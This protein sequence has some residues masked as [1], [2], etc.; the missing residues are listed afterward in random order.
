MGRRWGKT[1]LGSELLIEAALTGKPVGYFAPTYKLLVPAWRDVAR[2]CLPIIKGAPNKTEHRLE[3]VTGGAI[4]MWSLDGG[5]AG[6]GRKYARV[7]LDECAMV[8]DLEATYNEAIR[9]TLT[10]YKG[11]AWFLSTPKGMNF[12]WKC[13]TYGMS[14]D[15]PDWESWQMPT[16]ANP[17]IDPAEVEDARRQLP[18]RVFRQE[19]LA[20]F[21]EDAGGVFRGAREAV[22]AGR[23]L[24]IE[25]QPGTSYTLG[26]D[27]ARVE[28]FTVLTVLDSQRRQVYFERFNQISWERQITAID[29]CAKRYHARVLVDS[30]GVG[31]PIFEQLR[32]RGLNVEGVQLTNTSKEQ[33]IDALAIAIEQS[34]I[35]L[36]D[37][38][39]QTNE[40]LAYQYELTASRNVRMNAP[41]GMHDDTVIA[42]ALANWGVGSERIPRLRQ[43]GV[44]A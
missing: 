42:L 14:A 8:G 7:V 27:L 40:L 29:A 4:E 15:E 37:V 31:D 32:A 13:F 26:V 18:D 10:D 44:S 9:P 20:E 5:N 43:L 1:I 35:R 30:T 36:M 3:L 33:I 22:D 2:L 11:D 25:Y 41:A 16:T 6:R 38:T 24:S 23:S 12:F 34:Q 21:I 39:E 19:Y 28:D 17:F